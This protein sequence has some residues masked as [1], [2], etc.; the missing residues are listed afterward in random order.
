MG[1]AFREGSVEAEGFCIRYHEAGEGPPLV[2]LHGAGGLR[3]TSAHDL[4]S[5][6]FRVIAFEMPGFGSIENQRT[7]TIQDLATTMAAA[8]EALDITRFNL[9]GTSF[10]GTVASWIAI[11]RDALLSALV[12]HA[13][14]AIRPEGAQPGSWLARGDRAPT[15]RPSGNGS[16]PRPQSIR[17]WPRGDWSWCSGC[18]AQDERGV[19][20][21]PAQ[22]ENSSALVLF[23]TQDG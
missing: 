9:M 7:N 15:L 1:S 17:H 22:V 11:Q 4:L 16:L 19:G 13:P 12:L 6:A 2:H 18:V 5:R 21:R 10:G 20:E 3:L 23:G 14:A 8:A